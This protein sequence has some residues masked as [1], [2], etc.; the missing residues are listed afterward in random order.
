M[1]TNELKTAALQEFKNGNPATQASLKNIF[2][3][4]FFLPIKERI[5]TWDDVAN[6]LGLHPVDCLPFKNPV[7]DR[8]HACNATFRLDAEAEVFLEGTI[9]DWSNGNQRKWTP[10]W[11]DDGSGSG[12]RFVVSDWTLTSA[13]ASA[14]GVWRRSALGSQ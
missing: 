6:E 2:G 10:R 5:K 3:D 4:K 7:N 12:F 13:S 14:V 1:I 8:Q 11:V 9:L